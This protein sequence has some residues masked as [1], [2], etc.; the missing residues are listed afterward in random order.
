[1]GQATRGTSRAT[2]AIMQPASLQSA[3]PVVPR[4]AAFVR[5]ADERYAWWSHGPFVLMQFMPLMA[6]FTG[7]EPRD[8]L[9]CAVFYATRM[10]G[11]TV[12]FHRGLT[13]RAFRMGRGMQFAL[14]LLGTLAAQRGPLWWV[15]HHRKHHQVTDTPDDPHTPTRGWF[16]SHMGWL[17]CPKFD[18]ADA[19]RVRDLAKYPE[20]V[21]LDRWWWV[22]ATV[23]G[24][25]T[26]FLWGASA[27]AVGFFLSTTIL[28]HTNF[29]V[30]SIGHV[31]GARA[32]E[33]RDHSRN[34]PLLALVTFGEGWH[35]NHHARPRSAAFGFSWKQPDLGY[36]LIRMLEWCRL[37]RDV[38][39]P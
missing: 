5:P 39:R 36:A 32:F 31:H 13:H 15:S 19:S 9:L 27:L 3:L 2:S 29:A 4:T 12:G 35:N 11:L 6:F 10:F 21:W 8:W 14:A 34:I 1:M 24:T 16:W 17:L 22:P 30:S 7:A 38:K 25:A 18:Q 28:Y 33:T 26:F 37:V 20:L 23:L